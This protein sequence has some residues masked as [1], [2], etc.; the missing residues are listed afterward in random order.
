MKLDAIEDYFGIRFPDR[1][2]QAFLDAADPIHDAS[3]FLVP[4]TPYPGLDIVQVNDCLRT[5]PNAWPV[6]LVAFASN[7]CGD[8][9]AYDLRNSPEHIIYIDP[10]L[11]VDE[12]LASD[13][14]LQYDSF[15]CWHAAKLQRHKA[16]K[17]NDRNA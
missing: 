16:S 4:S 10:D 5:P 8:Y 1:H 12:N 13:D 3:D 17:A 7:G 9:F 6:F 15:A 2:R 11:T 14:K